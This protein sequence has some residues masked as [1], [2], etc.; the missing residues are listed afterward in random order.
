[1]KRITSAIL[2][3]IMLFSV[4]AAIPITASADETGTITFE[5]DGYKLDYITVNEWSNTRV[6]EVRITNTGAEVIRKL[7]AGI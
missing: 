7:D 1:M 5:Y 6:I 2:S 3:M 4:I